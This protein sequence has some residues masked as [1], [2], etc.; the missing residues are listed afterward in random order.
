MISGI[1]DLLLIPKGDQ[2]AQVWD[3][4]TGRITQE[5]LNHYWVQLK[6][7]AYALFELK[8]VPLSSEIELKLVFVDQK[9]IL[10]QTTTFS[11]CSQDLFPLWQS[12]N[13]PWKINSDH[14]GQCPYGDICPR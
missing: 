8:R 10:T 6:V 3:F 13:E 1:P 11:Q 5:N 4:K 2:K 14:C 12:Q 7:Y 9:E